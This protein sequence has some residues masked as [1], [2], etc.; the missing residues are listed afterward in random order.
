M[1]SNYIDCMNLTD[2]KFRVEEKKNRWLIYI[3]EE[4]GKIEIYN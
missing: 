3:K 1:R 2:A 4:V